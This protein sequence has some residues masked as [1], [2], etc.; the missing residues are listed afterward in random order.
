MTNHRFM[1]KDDFTI[2]AYTQQELIALYR[3]SKPTFHKWLKHFEKELGPRIGHFYNPRQVKI[4]V[5]NLGI[6]FGL[7]FIIARI[8]LLPF[9]L[10]TSLFF[11]SLG[12]N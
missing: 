9:D 1:E 12:C 6:P 10:K 2:R 8:V 5:E 3:C 4:I 7:I 11:I